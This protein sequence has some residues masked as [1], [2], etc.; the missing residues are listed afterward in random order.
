MTSP[1]EQSPLL[2]ALPG[3]KHGF[4]GRRGGQSTG[5]FASLNVSEAS[6]DRPALVAT[7]RAAI[8]QA[9]GLP[10]GAL[11]TM[12]QIHSNRVLTLT[13]RPAPGTRHEADGVVTAMPGVALGILTA[14]CAPILFAEPEAAVI[15]AAHAGWKGAINGV[16]AN[17]VDAMIALG[18]RRARIIAAIGPTI[19]LDNYEVGPEFATDLLKQHRDATNRL[20]RPTGGREHFDLPGFVFDQLIEAGVGKVNDLQR[21]TY[22][23]AKHYFSHRRS[24]HDGTRA[25][26]QISVIGLS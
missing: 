10:A 16:I 8:L 11:T 19:S 7:N 25:G 23:H 1:F 12:S 13:E 5:D 22:G 6:G 17:T 24:T 3:L 14:D 20:A 2:A 4:F 9:L 26:R 21:C 18:A 15:G